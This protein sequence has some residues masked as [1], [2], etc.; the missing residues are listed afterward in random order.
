MLLQIGEQIIYKLED[1]DGE[2]HVY[3]A[4]PP[5]D[6]CRGCAFNGNRGGCHFKHFDEDCEMGNR[7]IYKDLGLYGGVA[8]VCPFCGN[9]PLV[10]AQMRVQCINFDC[11]VKP[12]TKNLDDWNT[13]S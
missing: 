9:P 2:Y 6:L 13:R 8:L 5:I 12:L 11:P 10:D 3:K 7:L 1:V 4:I